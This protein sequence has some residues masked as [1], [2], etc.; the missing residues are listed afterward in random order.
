MGSA[1]VGSML[2]KCQELP[3]PFS[4]CLHPPSSISAGN[5][6]PKWVNTKRSVPFP[7]LQASVTWDRAMETQLK[8]ASEPLEPPWLLASLLDMATPSHYC[9][10]IAELF[11]RSN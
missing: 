4:L 1:G 2:L 6:D 10:G 5:S 3:F 8:R 9:P 11:S 7:A